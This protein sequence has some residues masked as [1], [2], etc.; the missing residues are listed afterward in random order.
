MDKWVLEGVEREGGDVAEGLRCPFE[1][2]AVFEGMSSGESITSPELIR[3]MGA[4]CLRRAMM[5]VLKECMVR[6]NGQ[7]PNG[8]DRNGAEKECE[9][10][11]L[12]VSECSG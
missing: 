4:T 2:E 11:Q 8:K 10:A 6:K 12:K 9:Y 3:G 5:G 7:G 1:Y